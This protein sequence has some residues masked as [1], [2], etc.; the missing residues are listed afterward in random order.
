MDVLERF[1]EILNPEESEI[2]DH[3]RAF[4]EW[5]VGSESEFIPSG[6]DDDEIG[7]ASCRERV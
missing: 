6:R 2:L 1:A 3:L 5:Y 7:R 4:I